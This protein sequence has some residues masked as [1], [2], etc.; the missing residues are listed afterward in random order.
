[1][2]AFGLQGDHMSQRLRLGVLAIAVLVAA[3]PW[4]VRAV[5]RPQA[6][7]SAAAAARGRGLILGRVVDGTTGQSI[8][9]AFV[10]LTSPGRAI[11]QPTTVADGQGRF[12]FRDLPSGNFELV[13]AARGYLAG[14]G[15]AESGMRP[16]PQAIALA[17]G[18]QA[19]GVTIRLFKPARISGTI[20]DEA[21]D[22]VEDAQ[23]GILAVDYMAGHRR[24]RVAG[25]GI[26]DDRGDYRSGPLVPG[27]YVVALSMRRITVPVATR[28]LIGRLSTAPPREQE[29]YTRLARGSGVFP[30][31]EDG[32]RIGGFILQP[33][34]GGPSLGPA[35]SADGKLLAA[36]SV[37]YP[38]VSNAAQSTAVTL[39]SGEDRGGVNLQV[40]LAPAVRVSGRIVG[41]DG[42]MPHL[43]VSLVPDGSDALVSESPFE[44]GLTVANADGVFTFLGIPAGSYV[45]RAH[46]LPPASPPGPPGAPPATVEGMTL[47]GSLPVS[48]DEADVTD[49]LLTLRRGPSM[50]GRIVFDGNAAPPA[51]AQV[52]RGVIRFELADGRAPASAS[53]PPLR[54]QIEPDGRFR[55]VGL[56]AARYVI[57]V[58]GLSGWTLESA[59]LDGRD[60]SDSG[61]DAAAGA[62]DL[63]DV[64]VTLTD[65]PARVSG[66][67]MTSSGS[68]AADAAVLL[69]SPAS[70]DWVDRG[71]TPRRQVRTTTSKTG[72]FGFTGM[73]AGEYLVV[74]VAGDLPENWRMPDFMTAIARTATRVTVERR[75][76]RTVTLTV[77]AT[78]RGGGR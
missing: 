69:F 65:A 60:I 63:S 49:L 55:S 68:V 10:T 26:S 75:A 40:R 71:A 33:A 36:P 73:P 46:W 7:P 4:M 61:F 35:P 24:L 47:S 16:I 20:L 14:D 76:T 41:P 77:V 8:E 56:P 74:A 51:T 29:D 57:R 52:A 39:G 30:I 15:H 11:G 37:F 50:R 1:M 32:Y 27:S 70:A 2:P 67:V 58:E 19:T 17:D 43:T 48:V 42:P 13:A 12:V 62:D 6:P 78:P 44:Q 22:P 38:G 31:S 18:E 72:T 59:M 3:A 53:M 66:T 9:G 23:V 5:P 28:E 25:G 21:G 45:A 64:V 54:S 34:A